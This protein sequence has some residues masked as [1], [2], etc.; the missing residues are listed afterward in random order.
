[1]LLVVFEIIASWNKVLIITLEIINRTYFRAVCEQ[2]HVLLL[3]KCLNLY[4]EEKKCGDM[5]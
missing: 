4:E 3:I 1:V 5:L 2:E